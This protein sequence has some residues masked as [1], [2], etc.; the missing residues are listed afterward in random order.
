MKLLVQNTEYTMPKIVM[1]TSY[2]G[3]KYSIKF[4]DNTKGWKYPDHWAHLSVGQARKLI[5][6]LT[7][8]VRSEHGR[9]CRI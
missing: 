2:R 8:F 4:H 5:M 1:K 7:Y 6:D 9:Q 3:G